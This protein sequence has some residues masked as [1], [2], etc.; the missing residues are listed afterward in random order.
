MSS[1]FAAPAV[2]F[3]SS[4][5]LFIELS[6]VLMRAKSVTKSILMTRALK[7]GTSPVMKV[8]EI[9]QIMKFQVGMKLNDF[10]PSREWNRPN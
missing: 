9:F 4:I 2:T 8:M 5:D 10:I 7:P 1:F 6:P 3:H